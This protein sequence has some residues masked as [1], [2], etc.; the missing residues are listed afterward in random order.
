MDFGSDAQRLAM[1][2]QT[3]YNNTYG[4]LKTEQPYTG[5]HQHGASAGFLGADAMDLEADNF[6]LCDIEDS[7]QGMEMLKL[8]DCKGLAKEDRMAGKIQGIMFTQN[9]AEHNKTEASFAM[10]ALSDLVQNDKFKDDA[11]SAFFGDIMPHLMAMQISGGTS[12]VRSFAVIFQLCLG[13]IP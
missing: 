10:E 7:L 13:W 1:P 2:E 4:G 12:S 6:P 8:G 11:K 9:I 5:L 3:S